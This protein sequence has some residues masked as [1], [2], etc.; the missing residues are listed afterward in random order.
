LL[1]SSPAAIL[2]SNFL[3][4]AGSGGTGS[5]RSYD[6]ALENLR[7]HAAEVIVEIARAERACAAQDYP[8]RWML[9]FAASQLE[10]AAALPF[11]RT[12]VASTIPPEQSKDPHSWSTA[13]EE[14][15]LRTTAVDGVARLAGRKNASAFTSLFEFL[16]QPSFSIRR[17]AAHGILAAPNGRRYA[18]R[19]A[20]L[21]P[22]DQ[23]FILDMK[24]IDVRDVPQ[25]RD[26]RKHLPER[27]RSREGAPKP[28]QNIAASG[29]AGPKLR[30][31]SQK[32][33]K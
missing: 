23:R 2:I 21:L 13:A 3:R 4:A 26:P 25:V 27:I 17:A 11:L 18:S 8:T 22:S 10:H 31:R 28:V 16:A 9:I 7:K 19:I 1:G 5:E 24:R 32:E 20:D 6:R 12:V 33:T 15:I 14:T 30:R 29:G